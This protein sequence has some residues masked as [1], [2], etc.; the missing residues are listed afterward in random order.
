MS[1]AA[2]AQVALCSRGHRLVRHKVL[3]CD[4]GHEHR[5]YVCPMRMGTRAHGEEVVRPEFGRTC[6][7]TDD[8]S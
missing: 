6:R 4:A 1:R 7:D 8:P 5:V 2:E 3:V